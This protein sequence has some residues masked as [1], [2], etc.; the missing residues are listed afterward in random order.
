MGR[1]Y[2]RALGLLPILL[3]AAGCSPQFEHIES[4]VERNRDEIRLVRDEQM[5][6]RREVESLN[7]VLRSDQGTGLESSAILQAK[8]SQMLS[9][10]DRVDR[11]LDDNNEFMRSLS[12]RV[13]LLA[14]RLG[15]PTLGEYKTVS[16]DAA[17][18]DVL[19]EEGRAL[20]NAALLDRDR[21]NMAAAAEGFREF[22]ERYGRSEL[23]DDAGYW[24]G[25]MAYADGEY[26]Q[27]LAHLQGVIDGPRDAD[28]RADALLKAVFAAQAKGDEAAARSFL[29]T[30][31][32]DF[33]D[34]EQAAL[35]EAEM[36]RP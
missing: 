30:L 23:T 27:A 7:A 22:R 24:L 19:P 20:F 17:E 1:G 25:E 35:A 14:T 31:R 26:Q 13:D 2:R 9:K 8:I 32:R 16:G 3:L 15:L 33:P 4:A 6:I 12:A 34:S 10:L 18:L 5:I 28:R 11:K 21:G 29:E 36:S